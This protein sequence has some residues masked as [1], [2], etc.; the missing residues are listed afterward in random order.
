MQFIRGTG[1]Q[2]GS[3]LSVHMRNRDTNPWFIHEKRRKKELIIVN[4]VFTKIK[5]GFRDPVP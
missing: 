4:L 3:F 2:G 5:T 1:T